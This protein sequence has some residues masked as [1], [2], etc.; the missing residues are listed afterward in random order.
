M[1]F[2]FELRQGQSREA[3]QIVEAE[4]TVDLV[5]IFLFNGKPLAQHGRHLLGHLVG[6]FETHHFSTHPS[7]SQ[8]FFQREHQIVGF[9]V[10]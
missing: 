2:A 5:E 6:H 4:G 10:P 8:T 1:R 9:E 3:E 7:F